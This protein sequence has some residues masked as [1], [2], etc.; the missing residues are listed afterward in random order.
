MTQT[1]S[2]NSEKLIDQV[3]EVLPAE[4]TEKLEEVRNGLEELDVQIRRTVRRHPVATLFGALLGG[5]LVGRL[6]AKR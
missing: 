5:Y 3:A 1:A 6:I 2:H 4:A